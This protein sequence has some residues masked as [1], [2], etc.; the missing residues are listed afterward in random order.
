MRE[1]LLANGYREFQPDK[2]L[3]PHAY[4]A[5]QKCVRNAVEREYFITVYEYLGYGGPPN[6]FE[7]FGQFTTKR[8][9]VF[10]VEMLN[11]FEFAELAPFFDD[12]FTHMGCKPCD[13]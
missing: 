9:V 8:G 7:A 1:Q 6:A 4:K 11:G 10:N 3:K 5:Y 13:G 12:I 2:V